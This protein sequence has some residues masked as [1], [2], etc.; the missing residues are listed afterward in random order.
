MVGIYGAT[1]VG[2]YSHVTS[3]YSEEQDI[4]IARWRQH[5]VVRY[6]H[7]AVIGDM[8]RHH[9]TSVLSPPRRHTKSVGCGYRCRPVVMTYRHINVACWR[10]TS[11]AGHILTTENIMSHTIITLSESVYQE[12]A[13]RQREVIT[14]M[15]RHGD[16]ITAGIDGR[17]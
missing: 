15:L 11:H 6:S 17:R 12:Y 2:R 7:N 16:N 5:N 4:V 3:I 1:L 10:N 9:N 14:V 13:T 8:R